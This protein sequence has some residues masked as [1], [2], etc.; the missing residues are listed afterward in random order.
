M[1]D[2]LCEKLLALGVIASFAGA[3]VLFFALLTE[4]TLAG[5]EAATLLAFGLWA[6]ALV[7][8]VVG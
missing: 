4:M 3:G 8:Y 7:L 5:L 6:L 1:S 2:R